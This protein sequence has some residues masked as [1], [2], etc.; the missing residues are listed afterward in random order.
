MNTIALRDTPTKRVT[1]GAAFLDT[2][3]PGW[4]NRINLDKFELRYPDNCII[5][6]LDGDFW[7]SDLRHTDGWAPYEQGFDFPIDEL[8]GESTIGADLE[9][10]WR[11]LITQRRAAA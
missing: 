1:K 5:G 11:K 7:F 3:R 6:Q 2:H 8:F 9:A 10:A 4:D